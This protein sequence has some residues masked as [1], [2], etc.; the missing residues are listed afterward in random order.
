VKR[1]E[2]SV[3]KEQAVVSLSITAAT[4]HPSTAETVQPYKPRRLSNCR[5]G[6]VQDEAAVARAVTP[7]HGWHFAKLF[8]HSTTISALHAWVE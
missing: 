6:C 5:L 2:G 7:L 4:C 8:H 3:T 1:S